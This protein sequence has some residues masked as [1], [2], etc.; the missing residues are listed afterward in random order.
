MDCA[1]HH[2]DPTCL[3]TLPTSHSPIHQIHE[4]PQSTPIQAVQRVRSIRFDYSSHAISCSPDRHNHHLHF[5][6]ERPRDIGR[7]RRRLIL[8]ISLSIRRRR[9][10]DSAYHPQSQWRPRRVGGD[11]A[12]QGATHLNMSTSKVYVFHASHSL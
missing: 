6:D 5:I 2:V 3:A 11:E 4:Q 7:Y 12:Y 10:R 8:R 9:T 1:H